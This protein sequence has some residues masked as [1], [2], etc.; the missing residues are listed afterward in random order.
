MKNK[1]CIVSRNPA[2]NEFVFT[3]LNLKQSFG[4]TDHILSFLFFSI[5]VGLISG[6]S[7]MLIVY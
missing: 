3:E 1:N 2:L 7:F 5:I 4:Y 6:S